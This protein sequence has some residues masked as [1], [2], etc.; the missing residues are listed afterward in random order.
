MPMAAHAVVEAA[1]RT[2]APTAT[3]VQRRLAA[4]CPAGLCSE[5]RGLRS[6][7]G[8]VCSEATDLCFEADG[9]RSEPVSRGFGV[10]RGDFGDGR[11]LL[12]VE[13]VSTSLAHQK[14]LDD[15]LPVSAG[16]RQLRRAR[17]WLLEPFVSLSV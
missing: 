14:P 1:A 2:A 3:V 12:I 17:L 8:G 16:L 9:L 10:M 5:A 7:T 15:C 13:G 6:E 4:R 11:G